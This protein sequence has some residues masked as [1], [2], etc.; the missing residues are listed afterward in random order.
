M[1]VCK[2]SRHGGGVPDEHVWEA[3]GSKRGLGGWGG[4][5]GQCNGL[6][7]FYPGPVTPKVLI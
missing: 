2:S 6:I 3:R 4:E 1:P 7:E 5:E